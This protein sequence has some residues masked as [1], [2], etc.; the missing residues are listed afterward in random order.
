MTETCRWIEQ[1]S[2]VPNL[3]T[4]PPR[5]SQERKLQQPNWA[6]IPTD[7]LSV[8][9][10]KLG[11]LN[12]LVSGQAVCRPWRQLALDP[13]QE[14]WRCIDMRRLKTTTSSPSKAERL[15]R[16]AVDRSGGN[17]E[18]LHVMSVSE[19]FL[20][21]TAN[22]ATN[23]RC[24]GLIRVFPPSPE[25]LVDFVGRLPLLEELHIYKCLFSRKTYGDIGR[26][27]PQLKRL[28][29][30]GKYDDDDDDVDSESEYDL[31]KRRRSLWSGISASNARIR[32][33]R[34]DKIRANF[35]L[36]PHQDAN[37]NLEQPRD[38]K[39]DRVALEIANTMPQLRELRLIKNINLTQK[40]LNA[41]L[42]KCLSLEYLD[43][44]RCYDVR[45]DDTLY[46][47]LAKIK[48]VRLSR[49]SRISLA[50]EL[51]SNEICNKKYTLRELTCFYRK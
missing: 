10:Q 28:W 34:R 40:G 25:V 37:S 44:R 41:I 32:K 15:A 17:I 43:I 18:E 8:I 38:S 23:M 4:A 39:D 45:V 31:M 9:F 20:R 14:F 30:D 27:C 16:A 47:K 19:G 21:Y 48:S 12:V 6:E 26:A 2:V 24:C 33:S 1:Q 50:D 35:N 13:T 42:D 49:R 3:P 22:R 51:A 5:T 11:A 7:A 29:V 46:A 36:E